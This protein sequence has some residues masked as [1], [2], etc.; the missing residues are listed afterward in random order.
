MPI[1]AV[2][3]SK[4]TAAGRWVERAAIAV[5]AVGSA[6][7]TTPPERGPWVQAVAIPLPYAAA[8]VVLATGLRAAQVARA[9]PAGSAARRALLARLALTAAIAAGLHRPRRPA[10]WGTPRRGPV[11]RVVTLNAGGG[12]SDIP[13]PRSDVAALQEAHVHVLPDRTVLA[14]RVWTQHPAGAHHPPFL[15]GETQ[16]PIVSDLL[17]EHGPEQALGSEDGA[18]R[19]SRAVIGWEQQRIAVYNVHFRSYRRPWATESRRSLGTRV[20]QAYAIF[21]EDVLRRASEA[22]RL[23]AV[24]ALESLPFI[25]AGDFNATP[26]QWSRAHVAAGLREALGARTP[27]AFTFPSLLPLVQIDGALASLHWWPVACHVSGP[28]GSDHRAVV[29]DLSLSRVPSPTSG[30]LARS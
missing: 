3:R 11:L 7:R 8:G 23:R 29:V 13:L 1:Q 10:T 28:S 30:L 6:A 21:R 24:L 17:L 14:P 15:D 19:Y 5:W 9:R 4:R 16:T 22:R 18:G 2:H 20:Y 26:D 27:W 12:H 25:V